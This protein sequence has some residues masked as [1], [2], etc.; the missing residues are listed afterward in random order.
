M[1]EDWKPLH[2]KVALLGVVVALLTASFLPV[3]TPA[4]DAQSGTVIFPPTAKVSG[5]T[6]GEWSAAWWNWIL[7]SP[8]ANSPFTDTTGANCAVGQ[9]G[10]V[11]FLAGTPGGDFTRS[12]SIPSGKVIMFPLINGECSTLEGTALSD[13]RSCAVSQMSSA[14]NLSA[15]V[16]GVPIQNLSSFHVTSPQ[17]TVAA[18]ANNAFGVPAGTGQSVADGYYVMV[19]LPA[20]NH[21]IRFHGELSAFGYTTG[22]TYNLRVTN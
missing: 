13:L 4:A 5:K 12:C 18:V 14:T 2:R 17:Y 1:Y 22:V 6:Y 20:G 19:Q 7:A 8:T 9:H 16:D 10:G 3:V 21:T 11:W 15:S